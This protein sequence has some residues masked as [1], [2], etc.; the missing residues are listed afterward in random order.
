MDAGYQVTLIAPVNRECQKKNGVTVLGVP[1]STNRRER[2]LVWWRLFRLARRLQPDVIHFHDPELLLLVPLFRTLMGKSVKIVY[3]VHEYFVDSLASK[4][5]I[6]AWLRPAARLAGGFFER[7]LVRGV[8]GI[9]CAVEGQM[10]LYES[11]KGPITVVQNL[12]FAQLFEGARPHPVLDV[13]GFKLVYVGLILPERGIDVLLEAMRLVHQLGSD[14]IYLFLIGPETSAAY[15]QEV[16]LFLETHDLVEQVHW[17]GYIPHDQLKHYLAAA[18]VGMA[19][20]LL[21]RQ[22]RNP[23]IA[24]KL[25][26]YMLC[27]L[28]IVSA[29]HPHRR[30]YIEESN[31][32]LVVAPEDAAAHAESIL[33]LRKHTEQAQA[34]GQRGQEAVLECYIWEQEQHKLLA[35]YEALD[36]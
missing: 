27:G 3:D 4:Y 8:Q 29:D 36:V 18:D 20:G 7:L 25:F 6:P 2:P 34:M 28:P 16:Q 23:G 21:T 24:T 12:P 15:M 11:F 1:R 19:P 14:D 13:E 26:E 10:A 17:L 5:W 33:W 35:F 9:I 22:Y 31:C 32:G 30:R